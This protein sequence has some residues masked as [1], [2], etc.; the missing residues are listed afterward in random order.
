M[1]EQEP[2]QYEIQIGSKKCMCNKPINNHIHVITERDDYIVI[3]ECKE[4]G[5]VILDLREQ[6]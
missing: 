6:L 1:S 3:L 4:M 2:R 5:T